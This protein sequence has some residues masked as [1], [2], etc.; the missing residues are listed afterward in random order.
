MMSDKYMLVDGEITLRP[1][2]KVDTE[3]IVDSRNS[4]NIF[5][6]LCSD[7]PTYDFKHEQWLNNFD[8][9]IDMIIH[10]NKQRCGRVTIYNIDYRNQKAE[11]GIF[12]NQEYQGRDIA[13]RASKILINYVFSNLNI[14]KIYLHVF[15]TNVPAIKLY[16][17]LG[18][19]EEGILKEEIYKNGKY[20][21]LIRMA[22][23]KSSI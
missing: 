2:S 4:L 12:V 8:Y 21:D 5:D 14:R 1:I 22:I 10:Y 11:Y 17:K 19:V 13:Y 6:N 7:L 16:K 23:F 15:S 18:F 3:F 20:R 9:A